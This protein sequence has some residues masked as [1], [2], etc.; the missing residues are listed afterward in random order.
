MTTDPVDPV[1][2]HS[3]SGSGLSDALVK[4]AVAQGYR[5]L[6][7]L[8]DIPVTE[9]VTQKWFTTDMFMELLTAFRVARSIPPAQSVQQDKKNDD[10]PSPQ[11][12]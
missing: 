11:N 2:P 10:P 4:T 6:Q 9:L 12:N 8:M 7:E 1:S 3:F 5:S